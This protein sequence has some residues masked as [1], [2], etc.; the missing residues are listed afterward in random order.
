MK[1]DVLGALAWTNALEKIIERIQPAI[2]AKKLADLMQRYVHVKT[3]YLR[4][5]IYYYGDKAGATAPYAG[6]EAE[7]GGSHDFV[8]RAI[9]A[10]DID[11]TVTEAL[12]GI[13]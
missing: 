7:R 3:G 2:F 6:Y 5:T 12:N 10:L 13:Y 9:D 4:S 11:R 8:S 1:I